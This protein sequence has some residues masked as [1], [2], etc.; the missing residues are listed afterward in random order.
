MAL[1]QRSQRSF[2]L[3]LES[4]EDRRL[5]AADVAELLGISPENTTPVVAAG[6]ILTF[7]VPY[8]SP[9]MRVDPNTAASPF[10]GVGSLLVSGPE[11]SGLASGVLISPTHV[12]TAG[13]VVDLNNDGAVDI[14]AATF[15]LNIDGNLTVQRQASAFTPHPDFTGFFALRPQDDIAIITLSEPVPAG[16]PI[17]DIYTPTSATPE[18]TRFTMVGYGQSG[19][20]QFGYPLGWFVDADPAVKRVGSNIM[21]LFIPDDEGSGAKEVFIADF[22]SSLT[23][24]NGLLGGPSLGN[25]IEAMVGPGDSGGPSFV[26]V[27]GQW[28]VVG[29]NTFSTNLF[30]PQFGNIMGGMYVPAYAD[31]IDSV[32]AGDAI[33]PSQPG[34]AA[35]FSFAAISAIV[36]AETTSAAGEALAAL[37][38]Q[39]DADASI[40]QVAV[41][42]ATKADAVEI[43][44]AVTDAVFTDG[45]SMV[46]CKADSKTTLAAE[47]GH[48]WRASPIDE[49]ASAAVLPWDFIAETLP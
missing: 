48:V 26:N 18:G 40:A 43:S 15:S 22:D 47:T 20:G 6:A 9:M 3:H 45:A 25:R 49:L 27:G 16:I 32:L 21:D 11:G 30:A 31:F 35:P 23:G 36:G 13:H 38:L 29:I 5:L 37:A 39:L 41:A 4:L 1:A 33:A 44:T 42:T 24:G 34:A 2:R 46:L 12:L 7:A 19:S 28:Q 10:A 8:D 17:Y 14:T